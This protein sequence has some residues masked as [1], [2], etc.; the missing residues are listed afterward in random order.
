MLSIQLNSHI[1][2]KLLCLHMLIEQVELFTK[3]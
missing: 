2:K 3:S 1:Q